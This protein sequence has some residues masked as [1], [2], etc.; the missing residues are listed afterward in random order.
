MFNILLP[1]YLFFLTQFLSAKV[2]SKFVKWNFFIILTLTFCYNFFLILYIPFLFFKWKTLRIRA[3]VVLVG[4]LPI[5][6]YPIILNSFGGYFDSITVGK[7]RLYIWVADSLYSNT[8][9][10]DLSNNLILFL[11]TFPI[12]PSVLVILFSTYFFIHSKPVESET[13]IQIKINLLY[14]MLYFT[15]LALM[16]YYAR[17][18]TYTL[19]IYSFIFILSLFIRSFDKFSKRQI[20]TTVAFLHIFILCSW[21]FSLGPLV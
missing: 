19:V 20:F 9:F 14:F 21:V 17:R 11:M 5:V 15:M 1:V 2:T 8:I 6:L 12:I 3:L 7:Y 18:L 10:Y 4:S 16:G 13:L